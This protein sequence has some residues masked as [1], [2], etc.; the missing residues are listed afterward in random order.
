MQIE[1]RSERHHRIRVALAGRHWSEML[2]THTTETLGVGGVSSSNDDL[3]NLCYMQISMLSH[4]FQS[5]I[6]ASVADIAAAFRASSTNL[7]ASVADIAAAFRASS[8]NM[9]RSFSEIAESSR[10]FMFYWT[11]V[12]N[13]VS[14]L[15]LAH[16][17][18]LVFG[19]FGIEIYFSC[20]TSFSQ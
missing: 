10:H 16:L 9:S 2:P 12:A 5:N 19:N 17:T 14:V 18:F 8:T 13:L 11:I 20:T 6:S 15:I 4:S 1:L 3:S 7:S